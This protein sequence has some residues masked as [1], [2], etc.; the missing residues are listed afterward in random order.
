[1]KFPFHIDEPFVLHF[2]E[3]KFVYTSVLDTTIFDTLYGFDRFD[4]RLICSNFAIRKN[5]KT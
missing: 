4:C 5:L 1:M 3:L 2:I